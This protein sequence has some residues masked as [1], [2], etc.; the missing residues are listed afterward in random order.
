LKLLQQLFVINIEAERF[1]GGVE[2]G[3]VN[4]QCN[5]FAWYGHGLLFLVLLGL[6]GKAESSE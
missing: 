2:I 6:G 3:A 4:E 1:S 5:F